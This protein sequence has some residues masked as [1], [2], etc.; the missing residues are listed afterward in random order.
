M[1]SEASKEQRREYSRKHNERYRTL[2][3]DK[4]L[5]E[6]RAANKRNREKINELKSQP[7]VDCNVQYPPY[8]MDFDH[9]GDFKKRA[10]VSRLAGLKLETILEEVAKC[11][12]VCA[13]CHRERTYRR[14][15]ASESN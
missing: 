3:R 12:L 2:N 1:R 6:Q 10:N 11:E 5:A 15:Q 14:T 9:V 8:V 7:C 13:N 4:F